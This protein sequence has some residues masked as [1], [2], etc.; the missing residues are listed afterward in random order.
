MQQKYCEICGRVITY[1]ATKNWQDI[2]YCSKA[3][4]QAKP[5]DLDRQLELEIL[6]QLARFKQID[7]DDAAKALAGEDWQKLRERG[8]NAAR[9][10]VQANK[11]EL[12]Q[13][14]RV[15]EPSKAKGK[16]TLRK[17]A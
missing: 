4:R 12:I 13:Q 11:L 8:R 15:L 16:L 17:K 14:G 10:L 9:R 6:R 2:K 7:I 5:N 1:R 3:C